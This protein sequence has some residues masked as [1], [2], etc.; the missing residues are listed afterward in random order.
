[1][2]ESLCR[3][4]SAYSLEGY[5]NRWRRIFAELGTGGVD[6]PRIL[7]QLEQS[8]VE[9][10]VIEQDQCRQSPFESIVKSLDYLKK[11]KVNI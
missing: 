6:L 5:D 1:M 3:K 9:W 11:Q 7:A 8:Q 4:N 10:W 2:V